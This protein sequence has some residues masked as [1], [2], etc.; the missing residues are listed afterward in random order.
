M[1]T[2]MF[3]LLFNS[4]VANTVPKTDNLKKDMIALEFFLQDKKD[5]KKHCPK[6]KWKQPA[7]EVYKKKPKSYLPKNCKK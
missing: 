6:I 3:M 2:G 5:Y 4:P 7:I 1:T